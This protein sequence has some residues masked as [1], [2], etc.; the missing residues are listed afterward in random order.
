MHTNFI[1]NSEKF[2]SYCHKFDS[3]LIVAVDSLS[4]ASARK[5]IVLIV[6]C[7]LYMCAYARVHVYQ[8]KLSKLSKLSTVIYILYINQQLTRL[9]VCLF[10]NQTIKLIAITINF[11]TLKGFMDSLRQDMP[12]TAAWIDAMREAFGVEHINAQIKKGTAGGQAFYAVENGIEVGTA[13]KHV[14]AWVTPY[15]VP[16]LVETKGRRK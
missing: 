14:G 6:W 5:L 9:I 10:F 13:F 4:R 1:P 16:K 15:I 12:V 3:W 11:L 8:N 7:R 2:D